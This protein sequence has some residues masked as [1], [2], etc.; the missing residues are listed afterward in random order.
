VCTKRILGHE[1][2]G[3]L[4]GQHRIKAAA[5]IDRYQFIALAWII[6]LEFLSFTL[7]VSLFRIC[8]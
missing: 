3:Y 2:I 4:L 5:D 6:C 8:L 1:L 7:N